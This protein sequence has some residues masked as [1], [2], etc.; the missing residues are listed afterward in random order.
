MHSYVESWIRE[1]LSHGY[2][3]TFGLRNVCH[4]MI[5]ILICL[6]KYSVVPCVY[7]RI[8]ATYNTCI[9]VF[10]QK[11]CGAV[12]VRTNRCLSIIGR[13]IYLAM[14]TIIYLGYES[15]PPHNRYIHSYIR[16]GHVCAWNKWLDDFFQCAAVCCSMLQGVAVCCSVLQS[17]AVCCSVLQCVAVCCSVL[18]CVAVCCTLDTHAWLILA[19]ILG[20]Q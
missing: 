8:V 3:Q 10:G 17:V 2:V 6:A 20:E 15:L 11:R 13:F 7:V 16:E 9:D 12:C 1:T 5:D 14:D 19:N 18:Q 4:S